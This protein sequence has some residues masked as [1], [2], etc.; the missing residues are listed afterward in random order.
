M[1]Q[2]TSTYKLIKIALTLILATLCLAA[3]NGESSNQAAPTQASDA[4]PVYQPAVGP[5]AANG[6]LKPAQQV[7]LSF[8][9]GGTVESVEVE[10]GEHVEAGQVLAALDDAEL[11]RAVAQAQV[12]LESA[13]ARLAQLETDAEPI[14]E[15]VLAATAAISS[16]QAALT[17]AHIQAGMREHYD[18]IDRAALED[19]EQALEDAQNEYQ[20]VL[21]D[22]RKRDW[23][24][25]SPEA[26]ALEEAQEYYDVVLAQYKLHAAD[27]GYAVAIAQAEAQLAQAQA[28]LYDAEHPVA[29]EALILAQLDVERAQLALEAAQDSLTRSALTAPFDGI[30][31]AVPVSMGE[32]VSPGTPVIELIDVSR[33]LVDT[34]N[35]GELQIARVREG[36]EATVRVNAF[37]DKA[38]RGHVAT[39]SPVAVVQQGDTT[40]TLTIELEATDLNLR[41]G[42]T[43]RVEIAAD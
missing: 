40:Y 28:A 34:K 23:A 17:Q 36:Q 37:Q 22:P 35:V 15:Q 6:T 18:T 31:S 33:W 38:L 1:K 7:L 42:M 5:I 20:K 4:N 11:A 16:A 2:H 12:E 10:V 3:C 30:I 26:R 8:G 29:P 39:V 25:D 9:V 41:P 14:P 13:Q 32:W 43:A 24:H 27:H 21:N 19:A